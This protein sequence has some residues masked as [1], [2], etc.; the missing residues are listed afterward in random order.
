MN[1]IAIAQTVD[2]KIY[3]IY[4]STENRNY[5]NHHNQGRFFKLILKIYEPVSALPFHCSLITVPLQMAMANTLALGN[6]FSILCTFAMN[7]SISICLLLPRMDVNM[8]WKS[9]HSKRAS[10]APC[11]NENM[12][13]SPADLHFGVSGHEASSL[14]ELD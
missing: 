3:K 7:L 10:F 14:R 9:T 11:E 13:I 5:N 2:H 8:P 1:K 12:T 4:F 6:L